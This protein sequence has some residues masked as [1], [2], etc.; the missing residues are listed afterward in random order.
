MNTLALPATRLPGTETAVRP[1]IGTPSHA[2]PEAS[3]LQVTTL[4]LW[5]GCLTVGGL[6]LAWGYGR[7]AAP[8]KAPPPVVAELLQVELTKDPLSPP[9]LTSLSAANPPPLLER[10]NVPAAPS[11]TAVAEP[12][13]A[14][15]FA[16][17]FEGPTRTVDVRNAR[18]ARSTTTRE[19][20]APTAAPAAQALTYGQG[21]GKQ[22]A[23]RY[24]VRARN[25]GQE[26]TVVVRFS[27]SE[28][29][30]VLD[31]AA[32]TPCPWPLLNEEAVR[33]VREL[34][35]FRPGALRLYEVAIHFKLRK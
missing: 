24:P 8:V 3:P 20:V 31:A 18:Y 25:A 14:V 30:R 5:L 35:R 7:P 21:E 15:A 12:S 32:A 28:T 26:G 2:A 19:A 23:P 4:V 29:G 13:P 6:G 33:T 34:W 22:A 17:P 11:L 9:E 27:V 16:L 10:L 1:V